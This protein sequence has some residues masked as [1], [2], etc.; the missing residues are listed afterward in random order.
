MRYILKNGINSGF[1]DIRQQYQDEKKINLDE[2]PSLFS[3]PTLFGGPNVKERAKQIEFIENM[4]EVLAPHF[5]SESEIKTSNQFQSHIIASRLMIASCL[6]VLDQ[7]KS[8]KR[9]SVLYRIIEDLLNITDENYFDEE[10]KYVCFLGAKRAIQSSKF[11]LDAFNA[12][13]SD[14]GMNLF[15]ETYW[16]EFSQFLSKSSKAKKMETKYSDFQFTPIIQSVGSAVFQTAGFTL[17][18]LVSDT[19]KDSSYLT[20]SQSKLTTMVGAGLTFVFIPSPLTVAIFSPLIAKKLLD[21]F[22]TVTLAQIFGYGLGLLGTGTAK[23]IGLPLDGAY[24]LSLKT[25]S[26]I[27]SYYFQEKSNSQLTGYRIADGSL[28]VN[29][30]ALRIIS[31]EK[32]PE[33]Y[34]QKTI[35]VKKDGTIYIDGK[36]PDEITKKL[37]IPKQMVEE[38]KSQLQM[39]QEELVGKPS[40]VFKCESIFN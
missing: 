10:D 38:I 4:Y 7:I 11:S 34:I 30:M 18:C 26:M 20:S 3:R 16:E 28:I 29:G 31:E 24:Q 21:V 27:K 12:T 1:Q 35:E 2:T 17:G 40:S 36:S 9:N 25:A 22:C 37:L 15:S 8:S 39:N 13:L 14:A 32:I 19:F 6:Y 33:N 23:V 5:L